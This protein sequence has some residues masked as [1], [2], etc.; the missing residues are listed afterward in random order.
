M[1]FFATMN[2]AFHFVVIMIVHVTSILLLSFLV[3]I[4]I[5]AVSCRL[6]FNETSDF[7]SKIIDILKRPVMRIRYRPLFLVCMAGD[8]IGICDSALRKAAL[9]AHTLMLLPVP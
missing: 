8:P 6:I 7:G 1:L 3:G 9:M 4:S 5:L 2:G